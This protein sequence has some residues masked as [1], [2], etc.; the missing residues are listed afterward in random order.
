M[1][2]KINDDEIKR[3]IDDIAEIL[4]DL[5][6]DATLPRNIRSKVEHIIEVLKD[7]KEPILKINTALNELD[8]ITNDT[9]IQPYTRTQLWNISSLLEAA[10]V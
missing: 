9:N 2:R 4:N 6:D 10:L 5:K 1:R 8:E 3:K 7:S